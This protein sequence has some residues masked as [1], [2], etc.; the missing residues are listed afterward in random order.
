M[1]NFLTKLDMAASTD[2]K[3][4]GIREYLTLKFCLSDFNL[5]F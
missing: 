4:T 1:T 2:K 3:K 5:I